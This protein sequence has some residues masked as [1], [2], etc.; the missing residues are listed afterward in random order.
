MKKSFIGVPMRHLAFPFILI[1]LNIS[2]AHSSGLSA[3][4]AFCDKTSQTG[5]FNELDL[6]FKG[7]YFLEGASS[8][9]SPIAFDH[10]GV[11][12]A[13]K[14]AVKKDQVI[15]NELHIFLDSAGNK[16][17]VNL[18][19]FDEDGNIYFASN[20]E[21]YAVFNEELTV[22]QIKVI[23]K[24]LGL[25]KY[26]QNLYPEFK[27]AQL[28]DVPTLKLLELLSYQYDY[29]TLELSR[30]IYPTPFRFSPARLIKKESFDIDTM[31]TFTKERQVNGGLNVLDSKLNLEL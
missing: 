26:V 12:C 8:L 27:L 20:K 5:D 18:G 1:V 16:A 23:I 6:S 17:K 22:P 7:V 15:F 30:P 11:V 28:G 14:T 10:S 4:K 29:F 31:R 13:Y 2:L 19:A 3:V 25:D 9:D 21:A 24:D